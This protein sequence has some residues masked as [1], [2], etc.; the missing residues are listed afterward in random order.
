MRFAFL[1]PPMML[2]AACGQDEKPKNSPELTINADGDGGAVHI[3]SGKDGGKLKIDGTGVNIDLDI[4]DIADLDINSDF[5]ID[6][7]KLFPGS[8]ITTMDINANDKNGAN[9]AVV[10]FGFTS[11]ATPAKA[12]D[13]MAGEFAKK[14]IKVSRTGDTLAGTDKDGDAFTVAFAPDG[15]NAK[16]EVRIVSK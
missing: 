10:K 7:V 14:S 1:I 2:L 6:G 5:D 9:D 4:P 12:A 11:P 3:T 16:G 15:A 13:W 8:Q